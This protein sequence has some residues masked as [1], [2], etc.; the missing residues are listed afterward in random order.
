M[1]DRCGAHKS[2]KTALPRTYNLISLGLSFTFSRKGPSTCPPAYITDTGVRI[3]RQD[4]NM[5]GLWVC[6]CPGCCVALGNLSA[7]LSLIF[8]LVVGICKL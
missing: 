2:L 5:L 3:R 8:P 1:L 4:G 6:P 7:S